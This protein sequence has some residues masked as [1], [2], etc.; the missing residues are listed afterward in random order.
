VT[1]HIY[2]ITP[3]DT[4]PSMIA[5]DL[6]CCDKRRQQLGLTPVNI[7]HTDLKAKR[8]ATQVPAGSGGTLDEYVPFYFAP[9]SPMLYSIFS[10]YVQGYVG[11]QSRVVH[12]VA[13][14]ESVS[15]E[16]LPFAFS[17]GHGIVAF[18]HFYDDLD[19]LDKIDW[20]VMPLTWWNDTQQDPDRKRRRQAE[21]LVKGT[22]PWSLVTEIGVIDTSVKETVEGIIATADHR[23]SVVVHRN[24]YYP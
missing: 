22:F 24:W 17:D 1:H 7:A 18:S 15:T 8:A 13:D 10:G 2:Y 21:F 16:G 4:L 11:G 23:P 12:L 20:E 6:I 9:R 5:L 3:Y 14:C 19:D